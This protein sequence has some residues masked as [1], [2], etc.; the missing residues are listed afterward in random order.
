MAG[1]DSLYARGLI[2]DDAMEKLRA[3]MTHEAARPNPAAPYLRDAKNFATGGVSEVLKKRGVELPDWINSVGN[4]LQNPDNQAAMGMA[5]NYERFDWPVRTLSGRIV[6]MPVTVNPSRS[7]I[8]RELAQAP[9]G[10]V[11][12]VRHPNGDLYMWPANEAM[13]V[14]IANAFDM[15]FKTRED[16]Q[17]NSYLLNKGD[18]DKVERFRNFDDLVSKL[19]DSAG[20][21]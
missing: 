7:A 11:R 1:V 8:Q 6:D 2:S 19:G 12:A 4:I 13:H 21:P 17:R 18:V 5:G 14:D 20:A 15:P 9:H 10:D 16:L 3:L